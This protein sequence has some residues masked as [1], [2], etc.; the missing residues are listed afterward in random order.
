MPAGFNRR[1]EDCRLMVYYWIRCV[2]RLLVEEWV[3]VVT[4]GRDT[5]PLMGFVVKGAIAWNV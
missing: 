5:R 1:C 3:L 4:F 2:R